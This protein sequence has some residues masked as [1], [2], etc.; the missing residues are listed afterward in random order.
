MIE[1][2]P[3]KHVALN[4]LLMRPRRRHQADARQARLAALWLLTEDEAQAEAA[5]RDHAWRELLNSR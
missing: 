2:R 4:A 5:R 3:A 1:A